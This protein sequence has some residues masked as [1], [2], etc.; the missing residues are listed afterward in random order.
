MAAAAEE[1]EEKEEEEEA[2]VA[3]AAMVAAEARVKAERATKHTDYMYFTSQRVTN[4]PY[5][6]VNLS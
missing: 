4:A 3:V 5:V 1:E 2:K 6:M